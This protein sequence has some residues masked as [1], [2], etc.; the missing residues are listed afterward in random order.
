MTAPRVGLTF[1]DP[2]G[3]MFVGLVESATPRRAFTGGSACVEGGC[4]RL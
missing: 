1:S 2:R 3:F 4:R